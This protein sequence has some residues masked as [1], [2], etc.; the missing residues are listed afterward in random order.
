MGKHAWLGPW[1]RRFLPEHLVRERNLSRNTQHSYRDAL[2][3][4]LPFLAARVG[5]GSKPA[6][7]R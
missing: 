3:M 1:I 5:K 4:L 7:P 6:S 2:R